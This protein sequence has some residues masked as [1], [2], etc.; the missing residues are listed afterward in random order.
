[1]KRLIII[2]IALTL[3]LGIFH[4]VQVSAAEI[5]YTTADNKIIETG[6]G[7]MKFELIDSVVHGFYST[8]KLNWEDISTED[9]K[10]PFKMIESYG[11]CQIIETDDR[12]IIHPYQY[13]YEWGD[14]RVP[15]KSLISVFDKNFH[16]VPDEKVKF[17]QNAVSDLSYIN[18]IFYINQFIEYQSDR[19]F[20]E[21]WG[22][23]TT[24]TSYYSTDMKNWE[25]YREDGGIPVQTKSGKLVL[26]KHGIMETDARLP[27]YQQGEVRLCSADQ[28]MLTPN[29]QV[30]YEPIN[31]AG[32][33]AVGGYCVGLPLERNNT[34]FGLSKDGVY[35]T[36]FD[37]PHG[38]YYIRPLHDTGDG[39]EFVTST[40]L[41]DG[42]IE[43]NYL[44]WS[45]ADLEAAIQTGNTYVQVNNEI[46][47]FSTPPV[48]ESDRTLVPMRFLFE[49]LGADVTWDEATQ[50]AT[51]TIAAD[52]NAQIQTFGT[53]QA[54]SVSVSIDNTTAVVNGQA[55]VMDVPA[56]LINDKTMVPLRFLSENLGY[57]VTWDEATNT[58]IVE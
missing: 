4:A 40:M 34:Q 42:S 19:A 16:R 14:I 48:T 51:A 10:D 9:T 26:A 32:L 57:T 31:L 47:G 46:L 50:T 44:K 1:M 13:T 52:T 28:G 56:R 17:P 33:Y 6:R 27:K 53:A 12:F 54:K 58:A 11:G 21:N 38:G 20:T 2:C 7:Y 22:K 24:Q 23:P 30:V 36:M 18:G 55:K 8:D 41:E 39:I 45:Y 3:T 43:C 35:F 25:V 29:Q 49:K 5:P 15:Q 37:I